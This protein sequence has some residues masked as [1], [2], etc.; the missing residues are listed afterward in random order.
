[1]HRMLGGFMATILLSSGT[2]ALA[3]DEREA[4]QVY[5]DVLACQS[6][7]DDAMRLQCF[8]A[9][10]GALKTAEETEEI[11]MVDRQQADDMKRGIFGLSLPKLRLFGGG[12]DG[13]L[14]EISS[15]ITR[16][17]KGQNGWIMWLDDGSVWYQTDGNYLRRPD[18]GD[19]I[20]IRRGA[21]TSYNAKINGGARFRIKRDR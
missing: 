10:V 11:V 13:D 2:A 14:E 16:V 6:V 20:V 7:A 5:K 18:S 12:E 19:T 4:P 8:D 9:A 15:T 21:F 17:K 1:M 3:D